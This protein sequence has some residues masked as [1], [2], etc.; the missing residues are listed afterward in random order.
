MRC[1][2]CGGTMG[3]FGWDLALQCLLCGHDNDDHPVAGSPADKARARQR[4]LDRVISSGWFLG[5]G[6]SGR[7]RAEDA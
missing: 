6:A 3:R 1:D 4:V 7:G 2:R 5:P